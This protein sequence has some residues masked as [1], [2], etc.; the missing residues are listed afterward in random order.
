MLKAV[1]ASTAAAKDET[2]TAY[3]AEASASM[4]MAAVALVR[5]NSLLRC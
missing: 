1:V 5:R 4:S 2:Y 3:T